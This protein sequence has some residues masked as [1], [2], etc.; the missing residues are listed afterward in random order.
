MPSF[1][2]DRNKLIPLRRFAKSGLYT[3][4]YLSLL[5]Q[6]KKL[7]A[8]KIGRNYYTTQ[9]WFEEYLE[10][11]A[12]DKVRIAYDK[13][14]ETSLTKENKGFVWV[15]NNLTKVIKATVILVAV[16]IIVFLANRWLA[17]SH[18]DEQGQVAGEYEEGVAST[19]RNI[20]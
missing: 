10:R 3:P 13:L 6:R 11:H 8:K 15:K 9:E 12:R 17:P 4:A 19:S 16:F 20:E 14:F 18:F 7:K 1:S 2:S 5:V